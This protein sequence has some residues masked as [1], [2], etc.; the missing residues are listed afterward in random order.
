MAY[1][2]CCTTVIGGEVYIDAEFKGPDTGFGSKGTAQYQALGEVRLQPASI[3]RTAG[4][5][6]AGQVWV[7][8]ASRPIRA[9][10][11]FINRCNPNPMRLFCERCN[12]D[13]TIVE[14]SRG[15]THLLTECIVVGSPEINFATGEIS[16]MEIVCAGSYV[17][18]TMD[19]L[20]YLWCQ[21]SYYETPSEG[22]GMVFP[23]GGGAG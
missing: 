16:G 12:I 1:D 8:E 19:A 11:S 6:S 2:P 5:A 23:P 21:Q 17:V 18:K 14:K 9:V 7:T 10:L 20:P 4:A 15:V 13:V 3:E 22:A